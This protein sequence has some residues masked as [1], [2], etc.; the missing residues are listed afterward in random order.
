[1]T[2]N[3]T[4]HGLTQEQIERRAEQ[5]VDGV[6]VP[7]IDALPNL[8]FV[9]LSPAAKGRASR[10]YSRRLTELMRE[11][12]LYSQAL[13]PQ[14]LKDRCAEAGLDIAVLAESK[15]LMRQ[16]YNEI[17][18][19]LQ[20]PVDAL[21]EEEV[22]L[23]SPEEQAERQRKIEERA[24]RVDE[25]WDRFWTGERLRIF[26]EAQQ[27][28]ALEKELRKHTYETYATV[29]RFHVELLESAR[30]ADDIEKPYFASADEIAALPEA[31]QGVLFHKHQRFLEGAEPGFISPSSGAP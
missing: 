11:G 6:F 1:M 3:E 23:L 22:A 26:T 9:P 24:R 25:F 2:Q 10:A 27:V 31:V 7:H 14:I 29:Y 18:T 21:T 17:P 8:A 5:I 30:K 15:K 4:V 19:E 28:E 12:G 16:L 13:I 20:G